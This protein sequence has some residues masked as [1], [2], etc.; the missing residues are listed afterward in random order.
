M[1]NPLSKF[2][3]ILTVDFDTNRNYGL[4]ILRALAIFFVLNVHS[5]HFFDPKS[6]LFNVLLKLN[7]DGVTLFF[8]LSGFLIGSILIRTFEKEGISFK[9]LFNFWK[10]R[11]FRTLPNYLLIS[12]ILLL[13]GLHSKTITGFEQVKSYF[14][15][16]A[17]F[18]EPLPDYFFPESWS[19]SIE[20]W[21]YLLI[22]VFLFI[23]TA[24][25]KF[26]PKVSILMVAL[27]VIALSTGFR[28]YRY[29]CWPD[30][31]P[32]QIDAN[33]RK[34]VITRLDSLMYGVLG[35]FCAAYYP[36]MWKRYKKTLLITGIALLYIGYL[37]YITGQWIPI[38][39]L[40][41]YFSVQPIGFLC[42]I[43]LVTELNTGK[44]LIYSAITRFSIISYAIYL[45]NYSLIK[46][47]A[48]GFLDKR[49][50]KSFSPEHLAATNYVSFWFLTITIAVLLYK[51]FEKPFTSL[52]DL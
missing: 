21:F 35:A 18:K 26:K 51:Y 47:Y 31:M 15:F 4:D 46:S 33:F 39:R 38:Y 36:E 44:G 28:Y 52:R 29:T 40:V 8:V 20:E 24:V 10:R 12:F 17:N 13:L 22:P 30:I 2:K 27:G 50:F 45:I 34:Q 43:P 48:I 3:N 11:W 7:L 42:L 19:L 32:E 25:Y 5:A 49:L 23:M 6:T 16:L 41:I 14:Y 37:Q 9:T 1:N